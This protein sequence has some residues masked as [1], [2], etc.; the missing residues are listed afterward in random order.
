MLYG[1]TDFL[2]D[3]E[4]MSSFTARHRE[5]HFAQALFIAPLSLLF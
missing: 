5:T 1:K 2:I 3:A 4:A